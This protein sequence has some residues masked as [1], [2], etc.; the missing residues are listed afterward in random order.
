MELAELYSAYQRLDTI[1]DK[2]EVNNR[3]LNAFSN[4]FT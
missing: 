3:Y 2:V 4:F 1:V